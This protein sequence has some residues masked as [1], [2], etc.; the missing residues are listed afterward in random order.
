MLVHSLP[1]EPQPAPC[2]AIDG[3][4]PG[5]HLTPYTLGYGGFRSG[6]G[7]AISHRVLP[8][9]FATL[10]VD[11]DG[12][13]AVVTGPR[14]RA[15]VAAERWGH[16]V[17][18]GLTPAGV[19]ALLGMPMAELAGAT[20]PVELPELVER[21]TAATAWAGRYEVLDRWIAGKAGEPAT[22]PRITTAWQQLQRPDSPGVD[23]VAARLGLRRRSLEHAF[24]RQVG[25]PPGTVARIARFQRVTAMLAGPAAL[26]R[27]AVPAGPLS[28]RP[29][30]RQTDLL[31]SGT[32]G[33]S[34]RW[35]YVDSQH[36]GP[37]RLR[38][39]AGVRPAPGR[40]HA[41]AGP[42]ASPARRVLGSVHRHRPP[43]VVVGSPA[44]RR[45]D[46]HGRDGG[47]PPAPLSRQ[48]G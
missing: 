35:S 27:V 44:H 23:V 45:R 14:K 15:T 36:A 19:R 33:C 6:T 40:D 1:A 25:I 11:I 4:A 18:A 31:G 34:R 29:G 17:T 12:Q 43:S 5:H 9:A 24:Q 7:A 47:R 3:A 10:V 38:P 37:R 32:R 48:R 20:V 39:F 8:L 22:D 28:G 26:S 30:R 41:P 13:G 16:G 21:L 42:D 46:S 2:A